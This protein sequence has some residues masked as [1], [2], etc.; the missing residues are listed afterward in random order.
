M[1]VFEATARH[2][3][4]SRAADEMNVTKSAISR[5]IKALE[6][7]LGIRLFIREKNGVQLT[8]AA[9]DLFAEISSSFS[10]WSLTIRT[11]TT[12]KPEETVTLACTEAFA[13]LWLMPR[14]ADFSNRFPGIT[15]N[16]LIPEKV[17]DY[18]NAEVD[19][20]VR[21]ANGAWP[22]ENSEPLY[23]D[24][25]YPVCGLAFAEEYRDSE[26][27]PIWQ[28][29]LLHLDWTAP[30][31]PRWQDFLQAKSISYQGLRGQRF[32]KYTVLLAAAEANQGLALGWDAM[33]RPLI[34]QGK[35][36]RFSD[37]SL[38]DP[39]GFCLAWSDKKPLSHA[40]KSFQSWLREQA[41][42]SS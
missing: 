7:E 35:L 37:L 34:D 18:R 25:I 24:F 19:L 31:W 17:G 30:N 1:A 23:D 14:M 11:I 6:D 39:I 32:A 10:R 15:V 5:Q 27:S 16:Y 12:D 3:S 40:A 38:P 41:R 26:S 22:N 42:P 33:V 8:A 36:V 2:A 28:L 13:T 29:P 4:F 20:F 9:Q 21:P